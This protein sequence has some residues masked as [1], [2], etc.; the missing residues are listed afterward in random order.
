M[1]VSKPKRPKNFRQPFYTDCRHITAYMGSRLVPHD[2]DVVWE[3]CAGKGVLIDEVLARAPEAT[4]VATEIDA[5]EIAFLQSKYA[6]RHNVRVFQRDALFLDGREV[7]GFAG[8]IS[9]VIANPPY[10]AWQEFSR[11]RELKSRFPGLYVRETYGVFLFHCFQQLEGGGRLV[12]IVPDTFLWLHRHEYLRKRLLLEGTIEEIAI[13]PSK[14]FPGVDFGYSG[15]CIIAV[16][17]SLPTPQSRIKVIW[18]I[19]EPAVLTRLATGEEKPE[20]C[21][22]VFVPQR[23]VIEGEHYSLRLPINDGQMAG[24][25]RRC[26][27]G[28]VADI[29]TGFYSGNDRRWVRCGT[30]RVRGAKHYLRVDAEHIAAAKSGETPSLDG[31]R[32]NQC[33]IPIVRG[34]SSPFL[35]PTQWYVDW[36]EEAIAEYTRKGDNPARFQNAQYYFRQGIGVPMVASA[37]LTG[38][39][40]IIGCSTRVL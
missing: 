21:D 19:K 13:F 29:V 6:H 28:D 38:A 3:P 10:G 14:F 24:L 23:M 33:F 20:G 7:H 32:G 2:E 31:I 12:F 40:W 35:K 5:E 16:K 26:T 37:G 30:G 11:R 25:K 4:V 39:L 17:K 36:S 15:L 1:V 8:I 34:G 22:I 27:L 18:K 9:K